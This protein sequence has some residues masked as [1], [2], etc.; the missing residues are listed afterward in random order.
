MGA[1]SA[2]RLL[3]ITNPVVVIFDTNLRV[4]IDYLGIGAKGENEH[5]ALGEEGPDQL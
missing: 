4:V 1:G 3:Q 5:G 2:R